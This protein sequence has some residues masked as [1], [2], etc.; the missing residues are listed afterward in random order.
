MLQAYFESIK[1]VGHLLPISL[2]RVFIGYFYINQAMH[3]WNIHILSRSTVSDMLVEALAS[4]KI[5]YWYRFLL[6]DYVVPYWSTFAFVLVGV[7]LIVGISYLIGYV[8]RPSS[9]LGLFL[10]LNY[11]AVSSH[12]QELFFRLMIAC[13]ILMAWVGA[14]RCLGIDYYFY[15]RYRGFWW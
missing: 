15:K 6:T 7:Q 5:P 4:D 8:V 2:L 13:H 1:Y 14:G 3:D 11:L 12:Q 9:I 10:C